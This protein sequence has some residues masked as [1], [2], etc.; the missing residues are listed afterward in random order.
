M[1]T[2]LNATLASVTQRIIERSADPRADYL[3]T[4]AANAKAGTQRAGMGCANM[5]H[6]TAALPA[7]DKL[8]IHAERTPHVGIVSAYTTTKTGAG[9]PR[10]RRS[11]QR[12]L[13]PAVWSASASVSLN[14][15]AAR[16]TA[17]CTS[18][19][20]PPTDAT[21]APSRAAASMTCV[22]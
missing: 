6:T 12:S 7:A 13:T 22:R 20:V 8:K 1:S 10:G 5:A 4:M 3:N 9:S 17:A 16:S 18:V 2:P 21:R 15:A 19:Q 11:P 14:P